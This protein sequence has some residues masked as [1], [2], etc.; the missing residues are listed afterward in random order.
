M[1]ESLASC[2]AFRCSDF[3]QHEN[4]DHLFGALEFTGLNIIHHQC[5]D[6][7]GD[8]KILLRIVIQYMQT[9]FITSA[10]KSR[11]ELVHGEF[12]SFV[13]WE[14]AFS[15]RRLRRRK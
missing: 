12:L 7:S 1:F 4:D 13:H 5:R 2:F 15:N 14:I 9:K 3:A 10:G 11:E 6:E 8:T